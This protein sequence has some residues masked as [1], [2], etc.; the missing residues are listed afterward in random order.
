VTRVSVPCERLYFA[1]LP[2]PVSRG[3]RAVEELLHGFAPCVPECVDGV[4]CVYRR[5]GSGRVLAIGVPG[6]VLGGVDDMAVV[7]T[8]QSWPDPIADEIDGVEP[9]EVNLLV[10]DAEPGVVRGARARCWCWLAVVYVALC[11]VVSGWLRSEIGVS[12]ESL[13]AAGSSTDAL[14]IDALGP[15]ASLSGQPAMALMTAELR[16]L[17]ATR[18][19]GGGSVSPGRGADVALS[20]VL[21]AW[22]GGT[23]GRAEALSVTGRFVEITV[24]VPGLGEAEVFLDAMRGLEGCALVDE[25]VRR[26][27]GGVRVSLRL[28]REGA[29]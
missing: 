9:S 8:P 13:R 14:L 5:L 6:E 28:R 27:L 16:S 21:A 23:G 2:A 7:A 22:P 19:P 25:S 15:S 18:A 4:H 24:L 29:R 11:L 10:G 20:R 3:K 17:R 26:E 12:R 1:V